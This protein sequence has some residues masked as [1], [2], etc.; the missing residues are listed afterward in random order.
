M[1]TEAGVTNMY[2]RAQILDARDHAFAGL[3]QPHRIS[4]VAASGAP[5][6]RWGRWAAGGAPAVGDL[7]Q[8]E[9]FARVQAN[10]I[11]RGVAG[12]AHPQTQVRYLLRTCLLVGVV[13]KAQP[14]HDDCSHPDPGLHS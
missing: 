5:A 3:P 4:Q 2:H 8:A 6:G 1:L 11:A 14:A 12:N 13:C 10:N 7:T 9:M